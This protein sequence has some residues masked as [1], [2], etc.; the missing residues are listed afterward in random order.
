M[1]GC[2]GVLMYLERALFLLRTLSL[3]FVWDCDTKLRRQLGEPES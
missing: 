2:D 3:F 1:Y